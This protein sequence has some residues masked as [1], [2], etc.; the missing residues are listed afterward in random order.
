MVN[1]PS[2]GRRAII[3]VI[4]IVAAEASSS[5]SSSF[6][7]LFWK[8]F[9]FVLE[10]HLF[11]TLSMRR[12]SSLRCRYQI[13]WLP[14]WCPHLISNFSLFPKQYLNSN[15]RNHWFQCQKQSEVQRSKIIRLP[16]KLSDCCQ[17]ICDCWSVLLFLLF[18]FPLICIKLLTNHFQMTL[19]LL[20]HTL[21]P[22]KLKC[23]TLSDQI[24]E[25]M[26]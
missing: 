22:K 12:C 5:S 20:C 26:Q 7:L 1:H 23:F 3:I 8:Y 16:E 14:D 6:F 10:M 17:Y 2:K 24:A 15:R 9:H 19:T 11:P 13:L 25:T 18:V 4:I 21:L